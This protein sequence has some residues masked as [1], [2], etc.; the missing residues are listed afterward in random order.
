[1]CISLELVLCSEVCEQRIDFNVSVVI[2]IMMLIC[3]TVQADI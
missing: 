1:M 3:N 2:T